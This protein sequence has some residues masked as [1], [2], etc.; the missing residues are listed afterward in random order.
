MHEFSTKDDLKITAKDLEKNIANVDRAADN[1]TS[2]LGATVRIQESA[3]A[4][5]KRTCILLPDLKKS[6]GRITSSANGLQE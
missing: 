5:L 6:I 3:I 1:R 2:E 4:D